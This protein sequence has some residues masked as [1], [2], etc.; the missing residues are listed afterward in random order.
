MEGQEQWRQIRVVKIESMESWNS[1]VTKAA[2]QDSL[3]VVHFTASW[4]M[5]SVAMNPFFEELAFNYP[6]A[7][8]LTVDVDE[9]KEVAAKMEIKA[10]PTFL[11]MKNGTQ[12]GKLVGAN[13]E[14]VR[15]MIDANV[16][17]IHVA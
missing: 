11:L 2:Q 13:P 6:D 5:P 14:E 16:E 15:K 9:V 7:L 8:F 10:M 17:T 1:F 4:C 3:I 12:I